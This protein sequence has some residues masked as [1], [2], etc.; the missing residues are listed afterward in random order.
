M[1]KTNFRHQKLLGIKKSFHSL[2]PVES[3]LLWSI[4]CVTIN[5]EKNNKRAMVMQLIFKLLVK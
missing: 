4:F 1:K 5:E 2:I 3:Y